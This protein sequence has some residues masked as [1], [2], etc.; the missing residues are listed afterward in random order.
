MSKSKV[1]AVRKGRKTGIFNTWSECQ[2]SIMG[3][4]GAEYKSFDNMENALQFM[5]KAIDEKQVKTIE[6]L[7]DDEMIAYVDGSYD[8]KEKWYSY[9]AITFYK[10]KR[11]DF[12]DKAND[13]DLVEMRNVAGELEGAKKAIEYALEQK[14]KRLYLYY[15]YEGIEKWANMSWSANKQGTKDYQE[16]FN[17]IS[18]ELEVVFVK[19]KAHS[20]DKYNEEVDQLAK[21]A[22]FA[23]KLSQKEIVSDENIISSKVS[24]NKITPVFNININNKYV[25]TNDLMKEFKQ[26]WKSMN[27]KISDIEDLKI[28]ISR[29]EELKTVFQVITKTNDVIIVEVNK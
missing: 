7:D 12:S 19:V 28:I 16:Y 29:E 14:V 3:F 11:Q 4:S 13:I 15:D 2:R 9:G 21:E 1:Y 27:K 6:Q 22:L 10:N 23:T 8:K 5:N 24:T 26:K 20:G 18:K 17:R 25:N